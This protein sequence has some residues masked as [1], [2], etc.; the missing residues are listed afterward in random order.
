MAKS[1]KQVEQ[2]VLALIDSIG[3]TIPNYELA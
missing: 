1:P 2:E 3:N